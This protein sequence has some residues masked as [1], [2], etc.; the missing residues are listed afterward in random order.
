MVWQE[1]V[2]AIESAGGTIASTLT[3]AVT[4]LVRI[5]ISARLIAALLVKVMG[6]DGF[7][8]T[9][10]SKVCSLFLLESLALRFAAVV[11]AE[12]AGVTVLNEDQLQALLDGD[13]S[14]AK[15]AP[16]AGSL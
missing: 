7:G 3:K 12:A 9:K 2:S 16:K 1:I 5:A 8:T 4:H 15:A 6:P 14:G 10:H 11:Q 13:D